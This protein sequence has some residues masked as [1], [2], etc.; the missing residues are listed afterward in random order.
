MFKRGTT[1]R[2]LGLLIALIACGA[3]V[4]AGIALAASDTIVAGPTEAYDHQ[5]GNAPYNTDQGEVVPFQDSA[6]SHNVTARA[7]GLDV[8]VVEPREGP[9]DKACGEGLMPGALAA[10]SALGVD[11]A[12][13]E[14]AGIAYL[15]ATRT[16]E[17]RFGVR[18]GRGV[19]R[20]VLHAALAVT[21]TPGRLWKT[22]FSM[23]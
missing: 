19:R 21:H 13:H 22:T 18:A 11:P 1:G 9:I 2:R 14:L 10:L 4:Y 17:H 15:D 8:L 7:S 16:A 12:G 6:D 23:R 5:P 3:M 20:T